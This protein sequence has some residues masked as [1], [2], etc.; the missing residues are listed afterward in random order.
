M[1]LSDL[2]SPQTVAIMPAP[3]LWAAAQFASK[4]PARQALCQIQ[5]I[6]HESGAVTV[7]SC[8]GHKAFRITL[9][10]ELVHLEGSELLAPAAEWAKPGKLL[11]A[12]EWVHLRNDGT[13]AAIR[14]DRQ[15][16]ELRTFQ[17][18]PHP[19][20]FPSLS[21]IWPDRFH[22]EPGCPIGA[23]GAY[24]ASIATVAAKLC[25]SGCVTMGS[26][27]PFNPLQFTAD[28]RDSGAM[29]QFLLMPVQLRTDE[30]RRRQEARAELEAQRAADA[31]ELKRYRLAAATKL[32]AVATVTA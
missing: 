12:A 8:D 11:T 19:H 22:C 23:N 25:P 4:D 14:A 10:A 24:L 20:L 2:I 30:H 1:Q 7:Q 5:L 6:R 9:P 3:I 29:M 18:D 28:Y 26:N 16:V 15:T 13:A 21:Q 27:S 17:P 32:P 31:Q